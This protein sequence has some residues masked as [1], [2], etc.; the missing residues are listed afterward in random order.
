MLSVAKARFSMLEA[1]EDARQ[2]YRP[3]VQPNGMFHWPMH[4]FYLSESVGLAAMISEFLVQS[5]DHTVRVFPCWPQEK[6][7]RFKNLRAQGGFLVSAEQRAGRITKLRITSTVGG[8][9]RLLSPWSAVTVDGR[10]L[11]P[12]PS[13]IVEVLTRPGERFAFADK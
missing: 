11:Q 2:Y 1:L 6:D 7:A 10:T 8:R 13:G 3:E 9:L 5:V 4:G 12:D